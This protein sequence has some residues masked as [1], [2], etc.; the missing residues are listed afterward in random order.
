MSHLLTSGRGDDKSMDVFIH[1][2]KAAG[3]SIRSL[4]ER[5]YPENRRFEIYRTG[6]TLLD[7]VLSSE[8]NGQLRTCDI[9]LG[10][11]PVVVHNYTQR[12]CNYF[13]FLREPIDRI[14]SFYKFIKY[15]F[16]DHPAHKRFNSGEVT[17]KSF[18]RRTHMEA[19]KV[20]QMLAG[21]EVQM[22]VSLAKATFCDDAML[23]SAK[24]SLRNFGYFGFFH[25]FATS[26]Q[27]C[28]DK[29]NWDLTGFET[30]NVSSKTNQQ[31]YDE[32]GVT[33]EDLDALRQTNRFDV[34]LFDY[35]MD[36][37][38]ERRQF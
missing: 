30:R 36:L 37:K 3:S 11:I 12:H 35:A 33:A 10:H 22:R 24:S 27:E 38:E 19:N 18:C 1:I 13:T 7:D 32:E 8:R 26:V 6:G 4:I 25:D 2:P 5:N 20:T 17:F 21:Y 28:G 31:F 14:T 15:D 16:P 9:V 23:E 34:A 29:L